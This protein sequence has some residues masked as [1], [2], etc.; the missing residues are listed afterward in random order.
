[1]GQRDRTNLR[2]YEERRSK[3]QNKGEGKDEKKDLTARMQRSTNK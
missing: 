1:M 3:T 2:E